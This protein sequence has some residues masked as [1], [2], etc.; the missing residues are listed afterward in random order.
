[1]G[2]PLRVGSERET[3]RERIKRS[4][5]NNEEEENIPEKDRELSFLSN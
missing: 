3:Q 2:D 4:R 5:R 1:M